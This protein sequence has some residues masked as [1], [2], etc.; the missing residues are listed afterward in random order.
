M[1][2]DKR[3][4]YYKKGY[5]EKQNIVDIFSGNWFCSFPKESNLLS[6]GNVNAFEDKRISWA[7]DKLGAF[8]GQK[9]LELG[10]LE[11]GHSFMLWKKEASEI[12]SIEA[13]DNAF[14]KCLC[15]KEIFEMKNVTFLNGDFREY[16]KRNSSERFDSVIA[17]GVLYHMKNPVELL[18]LISKRTDRLYIWTHFYDEDIIQNIESYS[19]KFSPIQNAK[20]KDFYFEY[21]T[22][23][24]NEWLGT[25]EFC[26]GL[27]EQS[28]WMTKKS[29]LNCLEYFGFS[30]IAVG[31]EDNYHRNGPSLAISASK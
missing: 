21:A 26:G 28:K 11:G 25:N 20:Y 16:L 10:P 12:I 18:D 13:D 3:L 7:E 15:V 30:N 31:F 27:E 29:I 2:K 4:G 1:N 23:S 17:S 9:I 19:N 14:L 6:G 22:W 8:C 5:P 24:Y